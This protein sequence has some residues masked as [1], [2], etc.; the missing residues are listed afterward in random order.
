MNYY[1][2]PKKQV[3]LCLWSQSQII[4]RERQIN[5]WAR[6]QLLLLDILSLKQ[7]LKDCKSS[8]LRIISISLI[9]VSWFSINQT[10]VSNWFQSIDTY[11]LKWKRF[12]KSPL[13]K[14]NKL[15]SSL[16]RKKENLRKK[17]LRQ[18]VLPAQSELL[19]LLNLVKEED[20]RNPKRTK[21]KVQNWKELKQIKYTTTTGKKSRMTLE[22]S[23][24]RTMIIIMLMLI[25]MKIPM[26]HELMMK[27]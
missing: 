27:K 11:I 6:I 9:M 8:C 20:T 3:D 5:T 10:S 21:K 15:K 14:M 23:R 12:R 19:F 24:S 7:E 16:L 4:I 1:K 2:G 18:K 13:K 17:H 26:M 25:L 22:T